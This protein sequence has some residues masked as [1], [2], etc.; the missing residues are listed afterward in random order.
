MATTLS[1]VTKAIATIQGEAVF[2]FNEVNVFLPLITSAQA[3]QGAG[4]INFPIY[5][6]LDSDDV[7]GS[8]GAEGTTP[9][10]QVTA[11]T[12]TCT[13][14][15]RGVFTTLSDEVAVGGAGV[16]NNVGQILGNAVASKFDNDCAD[17]SFSS[18]SVGSSGDALTLATFFSGMQKI[19][20]SGAP[21][22]YSFVTNAGGI[23]GANGIRPLLLDV[24]TG[25]STTSGD[26]LGSAGDQYATSGFVTRVGLCNIFNSEE[27]NDD[28]TDVTALMF[29][30]SAI[31]CGIGA[32]GLLKIEQQRVA[33]KGAWEIVGSGFYDVQL[34][35]ETHG[36]AVTHAS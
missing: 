32:M 36:C 26:V 27:I 24:A 28:D 14:T 19:K 20:E 3:P 22:P 7:V 1:D 18:N 2:N 30:K 8:E 23:W 16:V 6:Q 15:R 34:G 10:K 17:I 31:V 25:A 21:A 13:P 11:S 35:Q 29:A 5:N 9:D 12:R 4:N 33:T